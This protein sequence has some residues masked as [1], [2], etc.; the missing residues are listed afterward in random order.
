MFFPKEWPEKSENVAFLEKCCFY[1]YF[2][3]KKEGLKIWLNRHLTVVIL[4]VLIRIGWNTTVIFKERWNIPSVQNF[5]RLML[6]RPIEQN[7]IFSAE[8][9]DTC[10]ASLWSMLDLS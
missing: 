9:T 8:L 5:D 10:I 2:H 6:P 7:T 1:K 3:A 4:L